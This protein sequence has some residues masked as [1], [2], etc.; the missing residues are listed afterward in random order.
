MK[1]LMAH[2]RTI[3]TPTLYRRDTS[4]YFQGE[5]PRY[6]TVIVDGVVKGYTISPE[7][8]EMIVNLFGKG[9]VMP[10][11]WANNQASTSLF[12]YHAVSDVRAL[13]IKKEDL[14]E[15]IRSNPVYMEEYLVHIAKSQASLLLRITG[16][17]QSRATEK[18]CYTLYYLAYHYGLE[19]PNGMHEIDLKL[20][21]SMLGNLIGQTRESTAKN[22]R[23]LKEKG[24]VNYTSSTYFVNLR[25]LESYLG[26]DSFRDLTM[27]D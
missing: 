9:T 25:Q 22:L 3:G 19:R 20:T 11:G 16:L 24:I 18:I 7:G 21:Q 26:E 12:N 27:R 23:V 10:M 1:Q 8:D 2:L 6:A 14:W 4:L 17:C 5:V 13:R 15:G